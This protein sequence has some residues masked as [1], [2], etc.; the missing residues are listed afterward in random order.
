MEDPIL[1]ALKRATGYDDITPR[2]SG[3]VIRVEVYNRSKIKGLVRGKDGFWLDHDEFQNV[4][5]SFVMEDPHTEKV[6]QYWSL[7][8]TIHREGGPAY[9]CYDPRN[10]T[11]ERRYYYNGLEHNDHGPYWELFKGYEIDVDTFINHYVETWVEATFTWMIHGDLTKQHT[12]YAHLED[13]QWYRRKSD[14]M[15][16]SPTGFSPTFRVRKAFIEFTDWLYKRK[17]ERDGIY[18][19]KLTFDNLAENYERG[20]LTDRWCDELVA[21]WLYN[22][23]TYAPAFEGEVSWISEFTE[24]VKQA[25]LKD[26]NIWEGSIYKDEE[27]EFIFLTEFNT[28]YHEEPKE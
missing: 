28:F 1:D 7:K 20:V 9:I 3:Y 8:K 25:L 24:R 2:P 23:K 22:G 26:I 21:T 19:H 4:P 17:R 16:D 14:R 13:G 12:R 18:P 6:W 11:L 10:K 15:L 5:I 27:A